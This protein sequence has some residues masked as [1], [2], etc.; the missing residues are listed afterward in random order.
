M[1]S[2]FRLCR[3]EINFTINSFDIV[4]VLAKKVECCLDKVERCFDTDAGVDGALRQRCSTN[5]FQVRMA[6]YFSAD[7]RQNRLGS[8]DFDRIL[9]VLVRVCTL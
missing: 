8:V 7:I 5:L 9:L 2:L 1:F 3:K 6:G 4:A